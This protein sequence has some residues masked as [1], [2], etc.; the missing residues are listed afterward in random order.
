MLAKTKAGTKAH[1]LLNLTRRRRLV[2][3]VLCVNIG[4][5]HGQT[6]SHPMPRLR[7]LL[8]LSALLAAA[9]PA[10]AEDFVSPPRT[11]DDIA[12]L[13]DQ[14]ALADPARAERARAQAAR[15]PGAGLAGAAL[16][17][18]LV[19]RANA[20]G[21]IGAARQEMRDLKE[22]ERLTRGKRGRS[23]HKILFELSRAEMIEGRFRDAISHREESLK[24]LSDRGR[25]VVVGRLPSLVRFYVAAGDLAAAESTLV[26]SKRALAQ[27][28]YMRFW[29]HRGNQFTANFEIAKAFLLDAKGK[30]REAEVLHRRAIERLIGNLPDKGSST[31]F[32]D[33]SRR[34]YA[35]NLLR[36]GRLLEA[37]FQ[38]RRALTDTLRRVGRDSPETGLVLTRLARTLVAQGRAAEAEKLA[39]VTIDVYERMGASKDSIQKAF[40]RGLLAEAL[41]AQGKWRKSLSQFETLKQDLV[42][43]PVTF[44]QR[45]AGNLSWARA[46]LEA[47]RTADS[48]AL[49]E[50]AVGRVL[51]RVGPKHG[52]TAEARGLLAAAQARAGKQTESLENFRSAVP[53]LLSRSRQADDENT[54]RPAR[55]ERRTFIL[56]SYIGLLADLGEQAGEPGLDTAAEAFRLA[57][58]AR[59]QSVQRALAA[60]AARSL[61][62]E[63]KLGR[64]V[65][66]EQDTLKQ[67]S[68]LFGLLSN[69]TSAPSGQRNPTALKSL[70]QRIDRL[71]DERANLAEEIGERFPEYADLINPPPAT[72]AEARASLLPGE[73]LIAL[74]V[75]AERTFVWA[76]PKEGE[77]AFATA[78][79]GAKNIEFSVAWLRRALDA[80]LETLDDIR[81]F[82]VDRAHKLYE[83]LLAPVEAAW[84]DADSLIVVPHRALGQLPLGLLPT[85]KTTVDPESQPLF[86]GYRQVPWLLRRA[87]VTMLPSVR[88]LATLRSLPPG[89]ASRR[90]YAGFG[91]ALF[92]AEQ[93]R[94]A[95]DEQS[96]AMKSRGIKSRGAIRLRAAPPSQGTEGLAAQIGQLPRLAE[97]ADEIRSIALALGADLSQDVFIGKQANEQVVKTMDLSGRRVVAFATHGLVPGDLD[98][99]V[100]PALALTAP[101]VAGVA[102]DGLLTMGEILGLKLNAD[103]VVLSACNTAAA[104]GAGAEAVSG[105]GRAFFYAG[106]RALL[107]SNWPVETTSAKALTSDIFR[108]QA[109]QPGLSRAQ[110]LRSAMLA[111]IDEGAYRDQDGQALFTYAH[112]IFWAPF[113]LIGDGR[114]A[115]AQAIVPPLRPK[116]KR[117]PKPAASAPAASDNNVDP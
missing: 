114:G 94:T 10:A 38:A 75:G 43:D 61:A 30:Y 19:V 59:G 47:G 67:I 31:F 108:R 41:A 20:A 117:R 92:N 58:V 35:G 49:T 95:A 70:R 53:I 23:R 4:V 32:I 55:E 93:S 102:G 64:L 96:A 81:D 86:A 107:V 37:E 36:Q 77:V 105:L 106:A 89:A 50:T 82:D 115:N 12:A 74:L 69:A 24:V 21:L 78:P 9:M 1:L 68:A 39:R 60:S 29:R 87:A 65:R 5:I 112:P 42:G 3:R 85:A 11:I 51:E 103:W 48:L 33:T 57:D 113:S 88:A 46:A 26:R 66:R 109:A 7:V 13:L 91:D 6:R 25:A 8:L 2:V 45:F 34:N 79:L 104:N 98:G 83:A 116:A 18:F 110:A 63:G 84:K 44:A 28:Q 15:Q 52:T 14:Q 76:L 56:E 99:L 16:V 97:T 17:N 62:G 71:R 80:E 72:I 101:Q 111:L 27:A 22:A 100:Q 54:S 90:A 73:T 40:A